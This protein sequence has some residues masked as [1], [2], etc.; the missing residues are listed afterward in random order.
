MNYNPQET[1]GLMGLVQALK[2]GM[3]PST[4]YS[5][6]QGIQGDQANR[7]AARQQR[8]G[9]LA[10]LL[11]GQASQG[12]TLQQTRMLADLQPGPT[13]PA[14]QNMLQTL[15]PQSAPLPQGEW[16]QQDFQQ[17]FNAP[18]PQQ[19]TSPLY[20]PNPADIMQQQ[21]SMV[22][23]QQTL[24]A[25]NVEAAWSDLVADA[26]KYRAAGKNMDEFIQLAAQAYPELVGS[27]PEKFQQVVATIF[28]QGP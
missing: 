21:A 16:G 12:A 17:Y 25:A 27:D 24:N 3:D 18:P 5:L 9:G 7:I 23:A 13:G 26:Q 22:E 20:Q 4:A 11:A 19:M 10:D 6:Y 14:V 28:H 15:Y 1:Q 2:A 8:L